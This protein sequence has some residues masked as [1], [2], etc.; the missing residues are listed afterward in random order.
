[1]KWVQG[2]IFIAIGWVI[3]QF[4]IFLYPQDLLIQRPIHMV[5]AVALCFLAFPLTKA[6]LGRKLR[7]IDW[8]CAVLACLVGIYFILDRERLLVHIVF[9]E[10]VFPRD[11]ISCLIFTGLLLEGT[12]RTAG[13]S[14]LFGGTLLKS[15][16]DF[17]SHS[18]RIV[19]PNL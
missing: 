17:R 16:K 11:W 14:V 18:F 15:I 8:V 19:V 3:Y 2:S 12:R 10:E 6:S 7:W 5:F 9:I 1:M 13:T 4:Y